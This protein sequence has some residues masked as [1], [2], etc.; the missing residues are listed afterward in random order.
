MEGAELKKLSIDFVYPKSTD[1]FSVNQLVSASP[2]LDKN[3]VYCNLLQCSHFSE[4]SICAKVEDQLVGFVSAYIIPERLNTL[5]VWQLVVSEA[6]RGR[7]VGLNMIKEI[8]KRPALKGIEFI[9]TTITESNHAS[10]GLFNKLSDHLS[11]NMLATDFFD[12][13]RH[14]LGEHETEELLRIGRITNN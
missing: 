8:L 4:T 9:E 10:L 5:F 7:G 12:K 13:D 3:S 1:G 6:I 14:F 11:A 2:P